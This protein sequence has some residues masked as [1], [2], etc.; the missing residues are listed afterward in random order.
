MQTRR[1]PGD[2][3]VEV[4]SH[5]RKKARPVREVGDLA[6]A[7]EGVVGHQQLLDLG[8]GERWIQHRLISGWL[9][10][11][12]RGA[13]AVG[14]R[15]ISWRGRLR[16][17]TLACG[18][19]ALIS[20]R[21]AAAL[22]NLKRGGGGKIHV[23]VPGGGHEDRDGI[24]LHRVRRIA[25]ADIT[26]VD[27]IPV[28]SVARTCLDMAATVHPDVLDDMLEAAERNKTFDLTAML[29][30]CGRGRRG[31]KAL[32]RALALYRP[33]PGWTRSR[34][35]KRLFNALRKRGAP[36]PSVNA[37]IV[38][39]ECDLVWHDEHLVVEVDGDVWHGTTAAKA[40]DPRRD[41]KLQLARFAT[42]RVPENRIVYEIDGVVDD[43]VD[44]LRRL[45]AR[46]P[47]RPGR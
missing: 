27:G 19:N 15:R 40:R 37:W 20:H 46:T 31:S 13:Y 25:P 4:S 47:A 22:H 26:T 38:D 30:A 32:K 6:A 21:T 10:Q 44:L 17:A 7:Q 35:E 14:H 43:V 12:F 2:E 28:M 24:V 23:T 42:F 11:V 16:A 39:Q 41:V 36:L 45:A 34:L 8:L 33:I 3:L 5:S 18:P 9:R 29:A 1:T